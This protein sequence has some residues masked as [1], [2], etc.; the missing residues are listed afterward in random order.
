MKG[1]V[2]C[3][4]PGVL[5]GV[6]HRDDVGVVEMTPTSV[7][8]AQARLRRRR[9]TRV[10]V[11]PLLDV[12]VANIRR[13]AKD[14]SAHLQSLTTDFDW[15]RMQAFTVSSAPSFE[16]EPAWLRFIENGIVAQQQ[17]NSAADKLG[18]AASP[19]EQQ[20]QHKRQPCQN[21]HRTAWRWR[22]LR[23]RI[24]AITTSTTG[25][26]GTLRCLRRRG[27]RIG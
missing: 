26:A 9:R 4:V 23:R 2:P 21:R 11:E 16:K 18:S 27:G 5:P 14:G 15:L 3:C 20:Q 19:E 13:L 24:A 12:E 1:G 6:G 25:A 17:A 8:P 7:S 22:V 10:A